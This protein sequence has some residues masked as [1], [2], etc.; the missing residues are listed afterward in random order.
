MRFFQMHISSQ[1]VWVLLIIMDDA[2]PEFI[3][4]LLMGCPRRA[5]S[6]FSFSGAV[7][8]HDHI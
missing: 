8:C 5:I 1:N 6:V 3:E 4:I 2:L 7:S